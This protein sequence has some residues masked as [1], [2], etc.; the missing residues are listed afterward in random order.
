MTVR[1]L[2][3][4]MG[5][6]NDHVTCSSSRSWAITRTVVIWSESMGAGGEAREGEERGAGFYTALARE[7]VRV[8]WT[9]QPRRWSTRGA[10]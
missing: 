1:F 10:P 9:A 4:R 6:V 7:I 5:V 8:E 2:V 3:Q